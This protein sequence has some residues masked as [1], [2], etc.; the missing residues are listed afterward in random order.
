[1]AMIMFLFAVAITEATNGHVLERGGNK[2]C[3]KPLQISWPKMISSIPLKQRDL[4]LDLFGSWCVSNP[5][6]FESEMGQK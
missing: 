2:T 1:M 3:P 5:L 6:E 4:L